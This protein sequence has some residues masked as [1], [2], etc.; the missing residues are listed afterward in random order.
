MPKPEISATLAVRFEAAAVVRPGD[1]LVIAV[2]PDSLMDQEAVNEVTRD[3]REH[4]PGVK[5]VFV[6][7]NGLA[8]YRPDPQDG[9]SDD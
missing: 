2:D 4:L 7:A 1:T 3:L 8:V 6:T 5:P 9:D